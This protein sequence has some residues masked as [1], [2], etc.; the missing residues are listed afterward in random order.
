[1][2]AKPGGSAEG[3][4]A[5]AR[6]VAVA[7]AV[8]V[9]D[10]EAVGVAHAAIASHSAR[11]NCHTLAQVLV[12]G[13]HASASDAAAAM[14]SSLEGGAT[15]AGVAAGRAPVTW[16]AVVSSNAA[17]TASAYATAGASADVATPAHAAGRS[18]SELA[19]M[20]STRRWRELEAK[21]VVSEGVA[22]GGCRVTVTAVGV[23]SAVT[24]TA[25]LLAGMEVDQG[26]R[27]AGA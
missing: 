16:L 6:A 26:A 18:T 14:P 7:V 2:G 4:G 20:R 11:C 15:A 3:A 23:A 10:G 5:G 21:V 22:P 25:T 9:A 27:P 19:V 1:M 12:R 13:R 17:T 24:A 8:A